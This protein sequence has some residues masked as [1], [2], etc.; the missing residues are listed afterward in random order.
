MKKN[1]DKLNILK[2]ANI[3]ILAILWLDLIRIL[4]LEWSI[5]EQYRYGYFVPF[6][7]LYL[8]YL[9]WEDR[10]A[11]NS[12][13]NSSQNIILF[14]TL[15]F[16]VLTILPLKIIYQSNPDWRVVQWAQAINVYLIT[17]VVIW[18]WTSYSW[19]RHFAIP[20]AVI[21]FAVPWLNMI[22]QPITQHLMQMV[23]TITV[24]AMNLSGVPAE[25]KGNLIKLSTGMVGVEEACSGVRSFQSTIMAGYFFGEL[26]RLRIYIRLSL[27][28][29]GSVVSILLNII[30]T[31][32][33]T[34]VS[35][36]QN[37]GDIEYWHDPVGYAISITSFLVLFVSALI[38][39]KLRVS[40]PPT[41]CVQR[42]ENEGLRWLKAPTLIMISSL[43]VISFLISEMWYSKNEAED[44]D[45]HIVS[46]NWDNVNSKVN[47][48]KIPSRVKSVL[49]TTEGIKASW[50]NDKNERW[51]VYFLSWDKGKVSSFAGVHRPEICLPASGLNLIDFGD[52]FV[53]ENND[54]TINISSYKFETFGTPIYVFYAVWSDFPGIAVPL[55]DSM[56]ERLVNVANGKRINSRKSIEIIITGSPSI[57]EAKKQTKEF[58]DRSL[59]INK[60]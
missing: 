58:L 45:P 42:S 53:W 15:I 17:L 26:F 7:T 57:E 27:I 48:H 56:K 28:I 23:A 14:L 50:I 6:L 2:Y 44:L 59:E 38:I 25:Q 39:N 33:L 22:E 3:S 1:L 4:E 24:D 9:R 60:G 46:I 13:Q 20:A 5:D 10:P 30:R 36:S 18:L 41:P 16:L 12:N 54:L 35:Y 47:F 43:F 29:F 32:I 51:L 8:V 52:S 21:L 11:I 37:P 31:Y 34:F 19:V 55:A 49:R 40:Q